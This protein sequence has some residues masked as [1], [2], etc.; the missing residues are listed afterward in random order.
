[1]ANREKYV[2]WLRDI[3]AA[4]NEYTK[5]FNLM[6]DRNFEAY[7]GNDS[8]RAEDGLDLRFEFEEEYGVIREFVGKPCSELEMFIA[9]AR[10]CETDIMAENDGIDRTFKWFWVM[11]DNLK[12]TR[13]ANFGFNVPLVNRILDK[14]ERRNYNFD[15]TAGGA[16]VVHNPRE[17]LRNVE[18]WYQMQWFLVENY[19]F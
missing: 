5:L 16:W 10:R 6:L 18:I 1:M 9:L 11:M 3:V 19:E 17:D 13:C 15:G 4:G 14:F 7:I 12:L 2:D 8:N